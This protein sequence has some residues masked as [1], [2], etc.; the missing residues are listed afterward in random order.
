MKEEL[1]AF[2]FLKGEHDGESLSVAF[3]DVLE[4]FGIAG[5]L[6][7]VTADNASNNSTMLARMEVYYSKKYPEAGFTVAWN[8]VECM[9]HVLNLGA[10]Q[11]LKEFQ[12]PIDKDNSEPGSD[13]SDAM[14]TAVSRLLF[15]CRKIRLSPKLRRLL[16]TVCREKDVKYLVPMIDVATRWNS[17]YDV[18]V[19][20]VEIK[21]V[22]SDT[23]YRHKDQSLI[24]LL[25]TEED[26]NCVSQLID[27]LEP[28]KE[29]TLLASK[30]GESL[31]VTSMIPIYDYCTEM[32]KESLKMFDEKDD[33]YIGIESAIE[34]LTHY[35]DKVS[36]IVG[37]ALI[38]EPTLKKDFL[39]NGLGWQ[40]E[41]VDSVMD[42]FTSS[43]RFY[44]EKSK[45][46]ASTAS[47]ASVSIGISPRGFGN[48]SK[49][50]RTADGDADGVEEF[51][52]YFN[53]PLAEM[54]RNALLFWKT[55][56][57]HY[58][59]L[60]AMAK[61]YLTVQA[62]SVASERAFSSGTDLVTADRCSL[63]ADTIEMTQFLKYFIYYMGKWVKW[64]GKGRVR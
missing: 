6:L 16:E 41:C 4:E 14:V 5:R 57:F 39:K 49:K 15:L 33:I 35:Y 47:A 60:S 24:K 54:G 27:V 38:L 7:G 26:W 48:Y 19:R 10:Q 46:S 43:F 32:L 59:I 12:Q 50:R 3:I 21:E 42:H 17:T 44:R 31:M 51:V 55:N 37:I 36:P 53:A 63:G 29:A 8:Q 23:F 30:N 34:K 2:K 64:V 40:V 52:R 20:A 45:A 22:M 61:D 58:P 18:L 9:A 13:L 1:L 25:L 62:S 28:L 11:V 56:Q